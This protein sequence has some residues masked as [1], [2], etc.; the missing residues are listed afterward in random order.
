MSDTPPEQAADANKD[1]SAP[2]Y[3][4][5]NKLI[6][7]CG[8]DDWREIEK[9]IQDLDKPKAQVLLEV[10]IA[11]MTLDDIR[12]L[13][14]TLRN[15]AKIPMPG[16]MNMQTAHI[17]SKIIPVIDPL[18]KLPI[19]INTD[20][21][22]ATLPVG[23]NEFATFVGS[24]TPSGAMALSFN[25]ADG[26]V[27]G[28]ADILNNINSLKVL[29]APHIIA[30]NNKKALIERGEERL[31]RDQSSPSGSSTSVAYQYKPAKLS[32]EITPRISD[33]DDVNMQIV[34]KVDEFIKTADNPDP[35]TPV[36]RTRRITANATVTNN[37]ILVLGG[38]AKLGEL[39]SS[40]E[41]PFLSKI[42][43]IGWLFKSKSNAAAKA[44]LSIFIKPIV[45]RP[46][47]RSGLQEHTQELVNYID[48][49][50]RQSNGL[51][52]GIKDPITR[53][54]FSNDS[55]SADI[56]D[57]F[58]RF[59]KEEMRRTVGTPTQN[60]DL[61]NNQ[62][63]SKRPLPK[64]VPQEDD[65]DDLM[66]EAEVIMRDLDLSQEDRDQAN[67]DAAPDF[68][69]ESDLSR[70]NKAKELLKDTD[71]PLVSP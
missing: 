33:N 15:P 64:V 11:D 69:K 60:I 55:R 58:M 32:V 14:T 49:Y 8:S 3:F 22:K 45:I 37:N 71:N 59:K 16:D 47:L 54:F 7:A 25:D 1:E 24:E 62:S 6:V 44:N 13:G 19:S 29:S 50:A 53:L 61:T 43:I 12:A 48:N 20:L 63:P 21:L 23:Q 67:Q 56:V 42:P 9:L 66:E 26:R 52:G 31:L 51:L 2:R 46:R 65:S 38:L 39:Q 40:S 30:T 5:G 36:I 34:I 68:S 28:V 17:N 70:A 10:L 27:W 18:T 35:Q 57:E 41:T 4:G